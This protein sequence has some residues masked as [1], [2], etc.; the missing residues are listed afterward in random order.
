MNPG[1]LVSAKPHRAGAEPSVTTK[2]G[3]L[4][5][6]VVAPPRVAQADHG[7]RQHGPFARTFRK[8]ARKQT[9]NILPNRA[10]RIKPQ[11]NVHDGWAEHT[12]PA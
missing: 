11:E 9:F 4:L 2:N 6:S 12:L 3:S 8:D 1:Y 10:I 5:V 7:A